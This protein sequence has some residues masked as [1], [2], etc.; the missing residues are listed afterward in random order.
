V[1]EAA[2]VVTNALRQFSGVVAGAKTSH[3]SHG[4]Q[5]TA[6]GKYLLPAHGAIYRRQIQPLK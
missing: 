2:R 4:V 5:H 1:A 3:D 6:I